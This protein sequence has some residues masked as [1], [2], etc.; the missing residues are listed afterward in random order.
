[1]ESMQ[2]YNIVLRSRLLKMWQI[3]ETCHWA[4]EHIYEINKIEVI[5]TYKI[6]KCYLTHNGNFCLEM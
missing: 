1:M 5:F 6:D 2:H 3:K 4:N